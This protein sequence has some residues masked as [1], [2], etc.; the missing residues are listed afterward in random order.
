MFI[1]SQAK[2]QK[3]QNNHQAGKVH[4]FNDRIDTNLMETPNQDL[5]VLE[6]AILE[7]KALPKPNNADD[8]K[9]LK[10]SYLK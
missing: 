2:Y 4:R 8:H 3:N 5:D 9:K 7:F 1:K 10:K 6:I